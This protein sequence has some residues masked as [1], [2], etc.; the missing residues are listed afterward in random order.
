M[1]ARASRRKLNQHAS[2]HLQP[3]P[4]DLYL[5]WL[6][7]ALYAQRPYRQPSSTLTPLHP[8]QRR[9]PLLQHSR[10]SDPTIQRNTRRLASA[11]TFDFRPS[12]DEYIP[13]E[14]SSGRRVP[15]AFQL[16][17][18]A[19]KV[20]TH[21][22]FDPDQPLVINDSLTTKPPRF[23]SFDAITGE[24][25]DIVTTMKACLHVGRFERATALMRR[26]N[27]IY[28]PDS[29]ALL[30]AHNDYIRETAWKIVSTRDQRLLENLQAWFEVDM[31]ARGVSPNA[32]TYA[33]MI[34]AVLHDVRR[35]RSGRS[36]RRYFHLAEEQGLQDELMN[37]LLIVLNE[38]DL[39]IVTSFITFKHNTQVVPSDP[40][41]EVSTPNVPTQ[42]A[43]ADLP[44]VRP[45]DR[46]LPGWKA[47]RKSLSVFSDPS[48]VSALGTMEGTEEEKAKRVDLERQLRMEQDVY[49]SAIERWRSDHEDLKRL[50][51]NG[52][53]QKTSVGALMWQWH[54][55]M[56]PAVEEE[57]ALANAA[58]DKAV[59]KPVDEDRCHYGPFLQYLD[60]KKLSA[61]T[62]LTCMSIL[63]TSRG[64]DRGNAVTS[65]VMAVGEAVQDESMASFLKT[66]QFDRAYLR[67]LVRG[68]R[69]QE[70]TKRLKARR[71]QRQEIAHVLAGSPKLTAQALQDYQWS[72]PVKARVG[73]LLLSKLIAG[74]KVPVFRKHPENGSI[75]EE[76]QPAFLH[77]SLYHWG[78]R[79]GMVSLNTSMY[80]KLT[81][82]PIAASLSQK[83]LPM[84]V[85]PKPWA[86]FREGGFLTSSEPIVRIPQGYEQ[87]RRYCMVA[88]ENGDMDQIIAGLDV[89]SRTPWQINGPVFEVMLEAWN[90]G[91]AIAGIAP[92]TP[93]LELP[94]EPEVE[95]K[96]AR[97][98]YLQEVRRI[99]NEKMAFKS[100]RCYQ[101]FQLEIARAYLNETFYFPHNVDFRGRAYPMSPFLNYMGPD[102]CRG[103]LTFGV[104]KPLGSSGLR[105]LKIHLANVFGYDKASFEERVAFA[106][107]HR[108]DVFES[109]SNPL[110]GKRWW[111]QAEDPW[112]CLAACK[113]LRNAL[114]SP[115]AQAYVSKLAVHQDG[116]CNGLQHYAALG[117]DAIGARQVNLEPG[118]RPSDIYTGVA[119]LVKGD[120]AEEAKQGHE[121]AGLL[122][123]K[124]TR[125][126]VKQTVMTNVYGVTFTG[127]KLQVIKQLKDLYPSFPAHSNAGAYIARKIFKALANMFNG[128]HDIQFWLGDCAGRIAT[129]I[130]PEQMERIEA[131]TSGT[132]DEPEQFQRTPLRRKD[133]RGSKDE[134]LAYKQ[135][136]IWTSPL[137]MPVVQPYRQKTTE[138]VPTSLQRITLHN[139]TL[140]DPVN[141]RKQLQAFP[142]NFIHSLDA[143]HMMLSAMQCEKHDLTFTAV[144]DSFWTHP[145]DVDTMNGVLRDTF[146]KMHSEDIIGRLAAEFAIRYKGAMYMTAVKSK[147]SVGKKIKEWRRERLSKTHG[148]GKKLEKIHVQEI[149]LERRRLKLLASE[150]PEEREEGQAMVTAN[151]IFESSS[152]ED[153]LAVENELEDL[154]L[155]STSSAR[156]NKLQANEQLVVGDEDNI[157]G[158]GVAGTSNGL[159]M[160]GEDGAVED[161]SPIDGGTRPTTIQ[162]DAGT[163]D[164]V[165]SQ[166]LKK[167]VRAQ[168]AQGLK[169]W[170]WR[171]LTF[172]P[173]PEKGE[174]DVSR[175]EKSQ[176]FF[177]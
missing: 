160:E 61:I 152:G 129:S 31:R 161:N 162:A 75:S 63:S 117:G 19:T 139:P 78:K 7:P 40:P 47:L 8:P 170:L 55:A 123:G 5:P 26:L 42:I 142:P 60:A 71:H 82:E 164:A 90:T 88:T 48:L 34:Q 43:T 83:H 116:T 22:P 95:D 126:V 14:N 112:Q 10:S 17:W 115:D 56:F 145:S 151:S 18:L 81:T 53:L 16:P 28:T 136:V 169:V 84:V 35:T 1:L 76:T 49:E 99:G 127:A 45:V 100:Q 92:D 24:L 97:A 157:G 109:A 96:A 133:D 166:K 155:G 113:E 39:G 66:L 3:S 86:G 174:F 73:A 9:R 110:K 163:L 124:I 106:E 121:L 134:L 137:K 59:K 36:I 37:V 171:P 77:Q 167:G 176:Y 147:S 52:T 25:S 98:K 21:R 159:D 120:I 122:D 68:P 148:G 93:T 67:N 153:D 135:S 143:T 15:D 101:N 79:V 32:E 85:E 62:I 114:A 140:A 132:L 91:E 50:G 6:C 46:E 2:K 165:S 156:T 130:T 128:A 74:A 104:G 30:T 105:W 131:A 12:G 175:I 57:I 23:R 118:D 94:P 172:P 177:S 80:D 27:A 41:G 150:K 102:L 144:H 119:E 13:F 149:L 108:G 107:A 4:A 89:L 38:Q 125:K 173:V 20:A 111:L 146:I 154:A 54:E 64:G 51:I 33:F 44:E 72:Q 103:L 69:V 58:E 70:V 65:I 141:K 158:M 138:C 168:N 11:A 87:G 29:P